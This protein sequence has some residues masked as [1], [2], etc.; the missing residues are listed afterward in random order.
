MAAK[1]EYSSGTQMCLVIYVQDLDVK[2]TKFCFPLNITSDAINRS[3]KEK[4]CH[5]KNTCHTD[6]IF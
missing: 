5:F 2:C 3:V 1:F 6:V 4:C